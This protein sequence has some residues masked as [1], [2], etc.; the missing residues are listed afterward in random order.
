[1]GEEGQ[2]GGEQGQHREA[3][4]QEAQP[5]DLVGDQGLRVGVVQ[6]QLPPRDP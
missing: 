1:V 5:T 3:E 6:A 4:A 2:R